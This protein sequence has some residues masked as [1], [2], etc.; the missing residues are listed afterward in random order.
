MDRA[1]GSRRPVDTRLR[2]R[3]YPSAELKDRRLC[4]SPVFP[5]TFFVARRAIEPVRSLLDASADRTLSDQVYEYLVEGIIRGEI[6]YGQTLNIK[7]IAEQLQVS[8]M[9][10]RDAIKRLEQENMVVIKPRSN[11]K[12]RVP[13]KRDTLDAID[14]RRMIE[15]AAVESIYASIVPARLIPLETILNAMRGVVEAAAECEEPERPAAYIELDRRFH[16]E[17]CS[18]AANAYLDRFYRQ[19]AMHLSMSFRYGVGTCHG[20]AATF[21]EHEA[22]VAYLR[23]NSPQVLGVLDRHLALSRGNIIEEWAFRQLPD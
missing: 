22:I 2:Y 16:T 18:L 5:Y 9:P 8:S 7:R 20:V 1:T 14:A 6:V 12:V 3:F 19:I 11:C 4:P 17:L 10:I 13:T 23:E 15:L 21:E